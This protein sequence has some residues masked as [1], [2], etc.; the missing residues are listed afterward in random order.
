MLVFLI[1]PRGGSAFYVGGQLPDLYASDLKV[2]KKDS[3]KN[4]STHDDL[5]MQALGLRQ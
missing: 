1:P 2:M 4:L 3:S 5:L